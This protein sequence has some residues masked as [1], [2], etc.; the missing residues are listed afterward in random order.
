MRRA[1]LLLALVVLAAGCGGTKRYSL[2]K[3]RACLA[4]K[5]ARINGK[6]DFVASTATGGA[7]RALLRPNFVTIAFGNSE[8]DAKQLERRWLQDLRDPTKM[9]SQ[10]RRRITTKARPPKVEV[11]KL[12]IGRSSLRNHGRRGP[13]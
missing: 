6:L 9:L 12:L 2:A 3:T 7:F 4:Q 5:G 1:A 10:E 11:D 8:N 13:P